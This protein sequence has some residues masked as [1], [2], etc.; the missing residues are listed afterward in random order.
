M[1]RT[2]ARTALAASET[3]R[4]C[5][6][7]ACRAPAC[8]TILPKRRMIRRPRFQLWC[9]EPIHRRHGALYLDRLRVVSC[10]WFGLYSPLV[11]D[12]RRRLFARSSL[13]ILD[14]HRRCCMNRHWPARCLPTEFLPAD[15]IRRWSAKGDHPIQDLTAEDDITP[16]P[17]WEKW[18]RKPGQRLK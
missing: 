5:D 6:E 8:S 14:D 12:Q 15:A 11:P 17:G 13:A 9:W 10:P 2:T 3:R 18:T 1:G 16:L 4:C 7:Q